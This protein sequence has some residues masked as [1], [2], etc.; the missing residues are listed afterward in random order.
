MFSVLL[1]FE[2]IWNVQKRKIL[3]DIFSKWKMWKWRK[4]LCEN[5]LKYDKIK[6]KNI[7]KLQNHFG[8][9]LNICWIRCFLWCYINDEKIRKFQIFSMKWNKVK[10]VF[11]IIFD[12]DIKK[13]ILLWLL[14]KNLKV[15]KNIF[16]FFFECVDIFLRQSEIICTHFCSRKR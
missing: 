13:C 5:R 10:G 6:L 16:V 2:W 3:H 12:Y 9:S 4:V 7:L 15:N 14:H 1:L 11:I 8:F